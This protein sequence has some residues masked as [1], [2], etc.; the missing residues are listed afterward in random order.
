MVAD[1]AHLGFDQVEVVEQPLGGWRDRLAKP[2]VS[3]EEAIGVP[4]YSRVVRQAVAGVWDSLGM[5]RR[6]RR[7][8]VDKAIYRLSPEVRA[9]IA[10]IPLLIY[11]LWYL[12]WGHTAPNN[13]TLHN[14]LV[15][16]KYVFDSIAAFGRPENA[17]VVAVG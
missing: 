14:L 1:L 9:Y 16:P 12:G 6:F 4:E 5:M 10:A 2:H 8:A 13:L 15:A 3:G 17:A 11:G 7:S